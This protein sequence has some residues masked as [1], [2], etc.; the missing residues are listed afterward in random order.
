MKSLFAQPAL[1]ADR[2]GA[3]CESGDADLRFRI[4][5]ELDAGGRQ[6]KRHRWAVIRFRD[7]PSRASDGFSFYWKT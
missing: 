6:L 4:E 5:S 1:A 2:Q 7:E 3:E